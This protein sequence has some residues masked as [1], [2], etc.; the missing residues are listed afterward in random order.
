MILVAHFG[1]KKEGKNMNTKAKI[2]MPY[3]SFCLMTL[4]VTL[5][6]NCGKDKNDNPPP[7]PPPIVYSNATVTG[8]WML[9]LTSPASV[10]NS[11]KF[12]GNGHMVENYDLNPGTLPAAYAVAS[13]GSYTF[14]LPSANTVFTGTLTS[15]T[16]GAITNAD[17]T[18]VTGILRKVTD[19]GACQGIWNGTLA[20]AFNNAFQI[21]VDSSGNITGGS[22]FAGPIGGK[23]FCQSGDSTGIVTTGESSALSR[24]K[25]FTGTVV[26]GASVTISGD[27]E[28]NGP[29][30]TYTLVRPPYTP[31]LIVKGTSGNDVNM[32]GAWTAP[33]FYS[34]Q[35]QE[36]SLDTVTF[37]GGSFTYISKTWSALITSNCT[38]T[39]APDLILNIS[40][41]VATGATG[42][43]IWMDGSITTAAPVGIPANTK[44]TAASVT[45]GSAMM[46]PQSD[47]YVTFLN[48][49]SICGGSWVKNVAKNV[50]NCTDIINA[51]S[52]QDYW[53]IDDSAAQL[54]W[55]S[56]YDNIA[57]HVDI[58]S[59]MTK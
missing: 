59:I 32:N 53:V 50:L 35:D 38:Q 49:N 33:C 52:L 30:G 18:P 41:S 14:Y 55:Y 44:A 19:L 25:F 31:P 20:S 29:G 1:H 28:T 46:T 24:L 58:K 42:T 57:W 2:L 36:D 11:M 3:L 7:P 8:T 39:A 6:L 5:M 10:T 22:G 16:A 4:A 23:L 37:N 21:E 51:T 34:A 9:K 45:Y 48:T 56:S 43:A 47:T 17:G 12:D 54:K 27:Y 26:P 13:N 15:D 40:G